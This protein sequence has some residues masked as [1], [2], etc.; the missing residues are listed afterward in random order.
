MRAQLVSRA[1]TF[2]DAAQISRI[3][4]EEVPDD[5]LIQHIS[6]TPHLP[7]KIVEKKQFI[8]HCLHGSV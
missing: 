3:A 6:Q 8:G 7:F 1:L 2:C 5:N 4:Q